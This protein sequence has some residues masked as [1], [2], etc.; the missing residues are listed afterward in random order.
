MVED[1]VNSRVGIIIDVYYKDSLTNLVIKDEVN[2]DK[3][4][5]IFDFL[6][7][8]YIKAD[9]ELLKKEIE[10]LHSS[11][12]G[13]SE[14]IKTKKENAKNVYK[15][16]FN[17]VESLI[18]SREHIFKN[19]QSMESSFQLYEFDIPFIHRF[20]LDNNLSNFKRIKF[21]YINNKIL[22]FEVIDDFDIENLSYVTID[23]EVLP[24][25]NGTFPV[26]E[27]DSIISISIIGNKIGKS[28]FFLGEGANPNINLPEVII[29]YFTN[30]SLMLDSFISFLK[31]KDPDVLWTYNGDGFDLEYLFKRYK[32]LKSE[33]FTFGFHNLVF[34]R[35][36]SKVVS[37]NGCVHLD[38]YV[39][40]KLLNY[41]QVFNYSKFDLNTIYTK[42]T[43][44]D[45]LKCPPKE[46]ISSY[47]TKDYKKIIEYNLDDTIAT[48]ELGLS[49][50]SIVYEISKL[51]NTPI[52]DVLRGSAGSF[53]EKW[54]I[55]Y[56]L[57]NNLLIPNKPTQEQI[58]LR[59]KHTF[60]GAFVKTPLSGLHKNIAVVDFRS[61]HISLIITYNISPE[62]IDVQG[63]PEEKTTLIIGQRVSKI[64]K[65]FVPTLLESLLDIRIQIKNK[66]KEYNKGTK[67]YNQLY[68]KQYAFKILLA[69]TYGY[70]GF[71][72]ARWY[73]KDCLTIM[74]HL[75]R[76]KIQETI[77]M[78]EDKGYVVVY[79]DSITGDTKILLDT[80]KFVKVEDLWDTKNIIKRGDGKE[81][82]H[83]SFK[84]LTCDGKH[85]V[86]VK[87]KSFIR[88]KVNKKIYTLYINNNEKISV[89]EDHSLICLDNKSK[90]I[91]RKPNDLKI[92]DKLVFCSKIP[93]KRVTAGFKDYFYEFLGYFVGDGYLDKKYYINL[94]AG[95]DID[96][97][98][99]KLIKPLE[100]EYN[101]KFGRQKNNYDLKGCSVV[102]HKKI[103]DL[104]FIGDC[105][106]KRIP[107]WLFNE[108]EEHIASFLR[109]YFS[110]DGTVI[111]RGGSSIIRVT[112]VNKE[113]LEDTRILLMQLGI[114]N[115]II[116]ETKPNYYNNYK[117][118]KSNHLLIINKE[119]FKEK[120]RF[121][122]DRKNKRLFEIN[123]KPLID[124]RSKKAWITYRQRLAIKFGDKD[125]IERK[126]TKIKK[127]TSKNEYVY[128]FS[129]KTF[130]K[131]YANNIL[132]HNTDSCFLKYEDEDKLRLDLQEINDA[133]PISM[134]LELEDLFKTGIF[135]LARSEKVAAKKKYAL[136][137]KTGNLKVKG[138]ELV[139]RDWCPLVKETQR[140]VLELVLA[141]ENPK[142]AIFFAK[143]VLLDL[144]EKKIPNNK[145][146]IQS[147][148]HKKIGNY[149]TIN[150]AMSA[151]IN[152]K[153]QG[154]QV[155]S[156]DVVDF[157][158]TGKNGKTISEKARIPELVSEGDYDVDYYINNQI[159]P[160]I[161]SILE[162]FDVSVDELLTGKKQK[163]LGDFI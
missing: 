101:I 47:E 85:N 28:I 87:P 9:N 66:Q 73:C 10:G 58:S 97:V 42:I 11:L 120:I 8:F 92:G 113:L 12:K 155:K 158:I 40:I 105:Y 38:V 77:K 136:M 36:R 63:V 35:T 78:F 76:T 118:K 121:V 156:G 93:T 32:T 125:Y 17:D 71:S 163:G 159:V 34:H 89:T 143:Q 30:E 61:F 7:Y 3:S 127:K 157:I 161:H 20:F 44:K 103:R 119:I 69:S 91:E 46:M 26:P 112:S 54:F 50:Y 114:S 43:G 23:L 5:Y 139:R 130:E 81:E 95:K 52:F 152:A 24:P 41:L 129:I 145:L 134:S 13:V 111:E 100:K 116:T 55:N 62:T 57:K 37:I 2:G 131:F 33:D 124:D 21:N 74:Y 68:A 4:T 108:T 82:I 60:Q 147:F 53:V 99:N 109:G 138:F 72:G 27:N 45:K 80:Y 128:D 39:L 48:Q 110:A 15:I 117:G 106:S 104:G 86:F 153:E 79:G 18:I 122:L 75:V 126:I 135:V 31:E 88:H 6:P 123:G 90:L 150:P 98:Y 22:S 25:R 64:P 133:L 140:K 162:V 160:A 1:V 67:E 49:Y 14:I 132:V 151:I 141:Q 96:E 142:E 137:D 102:L 94:S 16:I 70:M 115:S 146:I 84:I 83:P 29:N 51:I 59:M 56:Y 149:K 65:G 154:V 19:Y 144:K 107:T 148:V